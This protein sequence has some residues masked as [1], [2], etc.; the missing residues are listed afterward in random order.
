MTFPLGGLNRAAAP[1]AR[2]VWDS[3]V[4]TQGTYEGTV[5]PRSF[6][7]STQSGRVWVS[8]NATEHVAEFVLGRAATL[9]PEAARLVSEIQLANLQGAINAAGRMGIKY[10]ELMKVG[11]W[12]LVFQPP[13]AAGQLPTV[14]HAL[15]K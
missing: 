13:R 5:I 4:A 2:T 10:G 8:N 7:L 1:V 12:E 9:T 15:Y 14:T 3:I 6:E 11:R